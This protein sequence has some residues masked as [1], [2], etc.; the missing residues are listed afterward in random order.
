M[1]IPEMME[2]TSSRLRASDHRRKTLSILGLGKC[3]KNQRI[4]FS[5]VSDLMV[6]SD[7]TE[8]YALSQTKTTIDGF[9]PKFSTGDEI[10]VAKAAVLL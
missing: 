4:T 9:R 10:M 2:F 8:M 3:S 1:D 5:S 6:Q 7:E